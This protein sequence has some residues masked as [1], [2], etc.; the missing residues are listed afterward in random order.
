VQGVGYR[1]FVTGRPA[2]SGYRLGGERFRQIFI[3][4]GPAPDLDRLEHVLVH[5]APLLATCAVPSRP[6]E[7]QETGSFEI[8][9]SRAAGKPEIHVPPDLFTCPDCLA[10]MTTPSGRRFAYPFI[11]CTQ[12]GPRYTLITAMPYD[13]PNTSMAGFPLCAACQ[14]EYESPLDRRF[15]AQPL[16]CTVCGGLNL[17]GIGTRW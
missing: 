3:R 2:N 1:P 13:R 4:P 6:G 14:R 16:A 10:E 7:W 11:N 12:C 5:G 8:L 9:A 17:S 15:H